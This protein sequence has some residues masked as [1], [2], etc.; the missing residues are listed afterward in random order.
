[1]E[2]NINY[3]MLNKDIFETFLVD[4]TIGK[5]VSNVCFHISE[6]FLLLS[7]MVQGDR[8]LSTSFCALI[9]TFLSVCQR[10]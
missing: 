1:M 8:Y 9:E 10:E 4:H 5:T 7:H 2:K 3:F 6:H